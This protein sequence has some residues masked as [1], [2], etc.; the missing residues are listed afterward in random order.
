MKV[1]SIDFDYFQDVK[2]DTISRCYPDGI[3]TSPYISSVIWGTIYARHEEEILSIGIKEKEM[4][5]LKNLL[6]C[7]NEDVPVIIAL[8]HKSIVQFIEQNFR[9]D[10]IEITNIDEHPD[11]SNGNP[12]LDCG[13]WIG[14]LSD[15]Y[16]LSLT[17]IAD[18]KI[19]D[20]VFCPDD[21]DDTRQLKSLI[22]YS[23]SELKEEKYDMVFLCRSDAWLAPHLDKDFNKLCDFLK[24]NFSY[25]TEQRGAEEEREYKS[26]MLET[27]KFI[28]QI[29]RN[30]QKEI[31]IS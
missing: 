5:Y 13:N 23:I 14:Y 22:N 6:K 8:S 24:E 28:G 19:V 3:D 7:Q 30:N 26:S 27:R 15:K 17:W 29:K 18:R 20:N 2:P 12:N 11:I 31:D 16:R 4:E 25:I 1:L 10:K 9:D 21:K